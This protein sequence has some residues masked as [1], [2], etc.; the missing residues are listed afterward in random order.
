MLFNSEEKN[1]G[2][3]LLEVVIAI[4]L[5]SIISIP[6]LNSFFTATKVDIYAERRKQGLKIA[7]RIMEEIKNN[8]KLEMYYGN[9]ND[10]STVLEE[11]KTD[12]ENNGLT[13]EEKTKGYDLVVEYKNK[14]TSNYLKEVIIEVSNKSS[15]ENESDI[16]IKLT[17]LITPRIK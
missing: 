17:S 15:K 11:I 2:M 1:C 9:K 8:S 14:Q 13:T 6:L 12:V 16:K 10:F 7:E 5:L 4:A 3:T